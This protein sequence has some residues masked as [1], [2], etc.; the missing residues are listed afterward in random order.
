[1]CKILELEDTTRL[2]SW[3]CYVRMNVGYLHISISSIP[4]R[5]A[6][7]PLHFL[8]LIQS[9]RRRLSHDPFHTQSSH[10]CMY[11]IW[12]CPSSSVVPQPQI[13]WHLS[14][15][16]SPILE[17]EGEILQ[18]SPCVRCDVVFN[19]AAWICTATEHKESGLIHP[20]KAGTVYEKTARTNLGN[21]VRY[22]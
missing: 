10:L 7:R 18:R 17:T 15:E 20:H 16:A 21:F 6:G 13:T 14:G 1:M 4:G 19:S 12:H 22:E 11:E 9:R 3:S 8:H 5:G 2:P